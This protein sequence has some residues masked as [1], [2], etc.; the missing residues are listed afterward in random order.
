MSRFDFRSWT[1][2]W[3]IVCLFVLLLDR[4]QRHLFWFHP[5]VCLV[6]STYL[7]ALRG[8]HTLHL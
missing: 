4:F 5:M 1:R 6:V 8:C 3:K 2:T 7:A